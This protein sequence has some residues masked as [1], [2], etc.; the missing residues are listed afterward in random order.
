MVRK[1]ARFIVA[2][3][4][5][6]AS[7]AVTPTANA[8]PVIQPGME[9]ATDVA[10]CTA[11]F[12]YDGAGGQGGKVYIG[13]AAHCVS[14]VG[15]DVSAGDGTVFGDVAM[16][17]NPNT[18]KDDYAFIEVRQAYVSSVKAAVKG[19]PSYPKGVT[20]ATQ[21]SAGDLIQFSGFGVGFGL[22]PI[23]QEQR[24]GFVMTD[25]A[26]IYQVTG[27]V[28]FGDSGG[29]L[30]HVP[31]GGA[32]GLVSRLC[33]GSLCSVEGPTVEGSLAKAAAKG[34]TVKLRTV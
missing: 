7:F 24:V 26:D 31:T 5:A 6:G 20:S 32:Y 18:S 1:P 29:P 22:L 16:I 17:G 15:D 25:N 8:A 23:T 30:V 34:F 4:I 28:I 3:A 21:T 14:E 11:N 19:H 2:L 13:T 10:G 27:P 9:I 12:V 33:V